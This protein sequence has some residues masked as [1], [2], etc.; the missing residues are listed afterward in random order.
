M[1]T[2]DL[3]GFKV[4]QLIL[5]V[6]VSN[7]ASVRLSKLFSKEKTRFFNSNFASNN[8]VESVRLES[9]KKLF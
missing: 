6:P 7:N 9:A 3:T 4:D 8:S 1:P 5:I 2:N